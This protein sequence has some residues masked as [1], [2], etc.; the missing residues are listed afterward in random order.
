MKYHYDKQQEKNDQ[1][2]PFSP[3]TYDDS[4][5]I[6]KTLDT[7]KQSHSQQS[8][9]PT[10]ILKIKFRLFCKIFLLKYQPVYLKI[11]IPIRFEIS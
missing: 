9:I 8:D 2:F 11:N 5:R 7:A 3:I 6:I 10:K 1:S 4:F